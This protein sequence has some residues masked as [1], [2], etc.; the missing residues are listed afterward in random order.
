M[1]LSVYGTVCLSLHVYVSVWLHLFMSCSVSSIYH[2]LNSDSFSSSSFSHHLLPLGFHCSNLYNGI[3]KLCY[4]VYSSSC[5]SLDTQYQS[6]R[7]T[8][9]L[10]RQQLHCTFIIQ[11]PRLLPISV[12][13]FVCLL[14]RLICLLSL[15]FHRPTLPSSF[16]V[17]SWDTSSLTTPHSKPLA[18]RRSNSYI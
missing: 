17:S 11:H 9:S 5:H 12:R 7:D 18:P 2:P 4:L 14:V 1:R 15:I 3:D 10:G 6:R 8:A 13:H 16:P